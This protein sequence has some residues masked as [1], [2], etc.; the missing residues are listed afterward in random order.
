MTQ[1]AEGLAEARRPRHLDGRRGDGAEFWRGQLRGRIKF[2]ALPRKS[3][4]A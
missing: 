4:T 3:N 2:G 1:R